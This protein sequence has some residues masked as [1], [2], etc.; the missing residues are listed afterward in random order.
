MRIL[1]VEDEPPIAR[2]I[3]DAVHS[4]LGTALTSLHVV[5]SLDKASE[6][7]QKH[8]IDLCFLD[9]NLSGEDGFE[10][11]QQ[12][13]TQRFHT[14]V[15]SG[16]TD[17]A[18]RAFEYGVIDFVPKPF[19]VERLR[20]ALERVTQHGFSPAPVRFLTAR[21]SR[22][23]LL[24]PIDCVE[25]LKANR[26]LV[27][28]HLKDGGMEWIEKPLDRLESILPGTFIRIHRSCI[29]NLEYVDSYRHAGR[30]CYQVQMKNG[31]NLPLSRTGHALLL[32]SLKRNP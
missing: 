18:L 21:T 14:I 13:L 10:L 25:Y 31:T 9:L 20:K 17:H 12:A 7:L 32:A 19:T 11:L 5:F 8:P 29:V 1:I 26:Y 2:D 22:R 16:H 30:G 4:I 6:I 28:V 23:H 27:E 24:L 15:I 3:G